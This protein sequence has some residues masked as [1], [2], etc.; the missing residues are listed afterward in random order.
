MSFNTLISAAELVTRL[1]DRNTVIVDCR[2]DLAQPTAGQQ[3]YSQGHI[4]GSYY[5][6]LNSVLSSVITPSSGRHPLPDVTQFAAHCRTWGISRDSQVIAYDSNNG[7][8]AARLWWLLHWLGHTRVAVLDGGFK[9]WQERGFPT[10]SA[11][12][13]NRHGSFIPQQDDTRWLN[14]EA[15][16]SL[17]TDPNFRLVDVR[18][19]ERYAGTVEPIDP[20][21]GHIPGA[22]NIPFASNLAADGKFLS[23]ATLRSQYEMQL[24]GV[25]TDHVAIMCG[26]GV[27]ACH[28]LLAL[29]HAGL[30]GAKL[31]AGSWSEWIKDSRR[32][33]AL[34]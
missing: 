29:A 31:Y 3:A 7:A 20:I 33:V 11:T 19:A 27:T 8:F 16:D 34:T 25:A 24:R 22:I 9:A 10:S 18:A 13:P 5:A 2:F 15:I 26:S 14:A 23:A 32:A 6:D 21:A 28:T 1:Q 17:R 4:P 12:T 30:D